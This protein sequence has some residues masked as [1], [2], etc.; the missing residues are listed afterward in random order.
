MLNNYNHIIKMIIQSN[1][2]IIWKCILNLKNLMQ[3]SQYLFSVTDYTQKLL[4]Q[5][6]SIYQTVFSVLPE[7]AIIVMN[8]LA[9]SFVATSSNLLPQVS[10]V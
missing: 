10:Y 2:T 1:T 6:Q 8:H 9:S 3:F 5:T 4:T 7:I